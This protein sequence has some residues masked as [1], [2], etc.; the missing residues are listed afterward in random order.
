MKIENTIWKKLQDYLPENCRIT[1][2]VCPEETYVNYDKSR[3]HLETY[4]PKNPEKNNV[5]IIFH[6]VGGNARLLSFLA[7]PLVN[8]GFV[9]ICPDLPGYGFT[10]YKGEITYKSWIDIGN[11][12]VKNEI[13]KGNNVFLLGLSAGGMLAYNIACNNNVQGL[14]VTNILDNREPEVIKYSAKNEFVGKYGLKL[15]KKM[16]KFIMKIRVPIKMVS[17]MNGIVNNK[18]ILKLLLKDKRGSG[19]RISLYFLLTMMDHVPLLEAE[20]FKDVPVLLAHPG[21]DKWTPLHVSELFFNRISSKKRLLIL[22]NAGHFPIEEPGIDQLINGI[23]EFI[24]NITE[25]K[26]SI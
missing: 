4:K 17:N 6:G 20:K 23:S 1:E 21:N 15:M 8:N 10:E 24:R 18:D 3:I 22:E 5:V 13:E 16:P 12:I 9:V 14:I 26:N 11:F 2:N 7:V 25:G 19:N